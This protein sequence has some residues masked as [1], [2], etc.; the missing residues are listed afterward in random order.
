MQVYNI[1]FDFGEYGQHSVSGI[2]QIDT[3]ALLFRTPLCPLLPGD[4]D[5]KVSVIIQENDSVFSPIDFHYMARMERE[6]STNFDQYLSC[7]FILAIKIMINPCSHCQKNMN[8]H[9]IN[10]KR[11]REY[12]E[13][14][15]NDNGEN[16]ILSMK[17]LSIEKVD[18]FI[19]FFFMSFLLSINNSHRE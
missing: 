15:E 1:Y 9:R 10:N 14:F 11:Q 17:Q 6:I 4:E 13:Y 3:K 12:D 18:L 8:Y 2:E 5:I 16:L 19:Y 7:F